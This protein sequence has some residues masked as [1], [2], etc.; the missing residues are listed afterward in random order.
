[1]QLSGG[2]PQDTSIPIASLNAQRVLA[3]EHWPM[4]PTSPFAVAHHG[5]PQNRAA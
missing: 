4:L 5:A 1:L 3:T 2:I